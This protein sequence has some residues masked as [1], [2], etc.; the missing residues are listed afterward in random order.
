MRAM[1]C[2]ILLGF[3]LLAALTSSLQGA[4]YVSDFSGTT[5]GEELVPGADP[6]IPGIDGWTQS[7][8]NNQFDMPK[9]WINEIGT[10][11]DLG[12]AI[13]G[14]YDAYDDD[15]FY[16]N[17]QLSFGFA[18]SALSLSLAIRDADEF[19][20]RNNFFISLL[21][22]DLQVLVTIEFTAKSQDFSQLAIWEVS[23][24]GGTA[25]AE[26]EDDKLYNLVMGFNA[27]GPNVDFSISISGDSYNES[28]SGTI[29]GAAS[30]VIGNLRIGTEIGDG[31]D[32]GDNFFVA[33]NIA[34]P[35]PSTA[36]LL[37]IATFGLMRR[38]RNGSAA[39]SVA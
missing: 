28:D 29:A 10:T 15:P 11:S 35:E 27:T 18:S 20:D 13:G 6:S 12:V 7:E 1:N 2:K 14:Y 9:A 5:P 22:T 3:S 26:V 37:G 34:I 30:A 16:I 25:F 21:T 17:R 39:E 24:N 31:D 8:A 38:R 36:L 23:V 19:L 4:A 32:W 33:T